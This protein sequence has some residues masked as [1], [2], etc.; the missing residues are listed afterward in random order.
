MS[1]YDVSLVKKFA[2][3]NKERINETIKNYPEIGNLIKQIIESITGE[4]PIAQQQAYIPV[5]TDGARWVKIPK[6]EE[7]K[8]TIQKGF[9]LENKADSLF[10]LLNNEASTD[11]LLVLGDFYQLQ[12]DPDNR[13][14]YNYLYKP[15]KEDET[16]LKFVVNDNF[17]KY[18]DVDEVYV[19]VPKNFYFDEDLLKKFLIDLDISNLNDFK[20]LKLLTNLENAL[21]FDFLLEEGADGFFSKQEKSWFKVNNIT[22]DNI[23]LEDYFGRKTPF[24]FEK[25]YKELT[26]NLYPAPKPKFTVGDR[27]MA[28]ES[29]QY[30]DKGT[31]VILETFYDAESKMYSYDIEFSNFVQNLKESELEKSKVKKS[32]AIK[33]K[34]TVNPNPTPVEIEISNMTQAQL[35]TLK[36]E[37]EETMTYLEDGDQEKN[38]LEIQLELV[39]LYLEN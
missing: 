3:L 13:K 17:Q 10:L 31:G 32:K 28:I 26:S 27:V 11:G 21:I 6:A 15:L 33:P 23:V 25:L 19:T 16:S 14:Q 36:E 18:F 39:N 35:L 4:E 34:Q 38:D 8:S 24:L 12:E 1:N 5:S 30:S 22:V 2:S 7:L 37:I 20:K 9:N 29:S